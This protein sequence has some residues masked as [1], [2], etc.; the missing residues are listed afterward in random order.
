MSKPNV[1]LQ[2]ILDEVAKRPPN[3]DLDLATV[4]FLDRTDAEQRAILFRE[5]CW[6]GGQ[7]NWLLK[8]FGK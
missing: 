6:Q 4:E 1:T 2:Q 3:P 5:L 7:I 8:Q